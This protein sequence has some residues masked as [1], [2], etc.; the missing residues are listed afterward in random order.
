MNSDKF[1]KFKSYILFHLLF[2][3]FDFFLVNKSVSSKPLTFGISFYQ[4][5]EQLHTDRRPTYSRLMTPHLSLTA[6]TQIYLKL[7]TTKPPHEKKNP[8]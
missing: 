2:S 8:A 6:G 3:T 1:N 7:F 4:N 5:K